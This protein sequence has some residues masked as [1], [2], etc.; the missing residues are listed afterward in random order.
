MVTLKDQIAELRAQVAHHN[1]LYHELDAPEIS[2]GD[3]DAMLRTLKELE[4]VA[5][6]V[7]PDSPSQTVGGAPAS[8][9]DHV[10]H[11]EPMQSLSNV[12]NPI[13]LEGWYPG[14]D[15]VCELKYDGLALNL[16]YH[17]GRLINA[18]TRGDGETGE[19]V[20]ETATNLTGVPADLGEDAPEWLEVRGEVVM[21][22]AALAAINEANAAIGKKQYSNCRNAAAGSL[23]SHDPTVAAK[24]GLVFY[25]Y[26]LGYGKEYLPAQ[27]Q[28]GRYEWLCR[29]GF[30]QLPVTIGPHELPAVVNSV[31]DIEALYRGLIDCRADLPVDID[32][33]V[34]K[35]NDADE[36]V[37]L[38]SVRQYPKW[39]VAYKF[40]PVSA[41]TDLLE[42]VYQV[43]RT[44]AVTPVAKIEPVHVGGVMIS[45][46]T[47]HNADEIK[48]LALGV[49]DKVTVHRAGDVIPKITA[50]WCIPGSTPVVF[51]THCPSCNTELQ[52][53]DSKV[54]YYCPNSLGCPDQK[55]YALLH[56]VSRG[57]ADIDGIGEATVYSLM[58]AGILNSVADIYA[59]THHQL[60]SVGVGEKV[61]TKLLAAIKQKS[62]ITLPRFLFGLGIHGVGASTAR[63]LAWSF[64]SLEGVMNATYEELLLVP[65]VGP[66]TAKSVSS[67]F[68]NQANRDI[69]SDIEKHGLKIVRSIAVTGPLTGKTVVFTGTLASM[70]RYQA[71]NY[72][73]ALGGNASESLSSKTDILVFGENAGSKLEKAKNLGVTVM[74]ELEFYHKYPQAV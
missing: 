34:I 30:R 35:V 5:G 11:F 10:D 26:G 22:K 18:V 42:V 52:R 47:L 19:D 36:Q 66:I 1:R 49:G 27:T 59:L 72:V 62:S 65:D 48:R 2:D 58:V 40:P 73:G 74:S 38:G 8:S 6:D 14:T 64:Q 51:P 55:L 63:D 21:P 61:T 45:S 50:R 32:G 57:A 25:C 46:V 31:E 70:D 69:I 67:W 16:T 39:A 37:E 44:G 28:A 17:Y 4:R 29:H 71:K 9:F 33:M 3:F 13:E 24:R 12:F 41:I 23:R 54:E 20:T 53:D 60:M 43:G 7:S 68:A 15:V 56:F